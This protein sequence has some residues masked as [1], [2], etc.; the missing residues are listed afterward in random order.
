VPRIGI[1]G[2]GRI[3]ASHLAALETLESAEV[4]A[5]VDIEP[6]RALTFR[7]QDRPVYGRHDDLLALAVDA[8]VVATPTPTHAEI[9]ARLLDHDSPAAI[10]VEKPLA[11]SYGEWR[12]L[13]DR[14]RGRRATVTTLLHA[15]FAPEVLWAADKVPDLCQRHGPVR[16]VDSLFC[17]PYSVDDEHA[18]SSYVSS[19]I[20]SGIN[21]LSVLARLVD[22]ER[23]VTLH[24]EDDTRDVWKAR[25]TISWRGEPGE[26]VVHTSWDEPEAPKCTRL[27]FADSTVLALDHKAMTATLEADGGGR[28][29]YRSGTDVPRL[30]Q[31]YRNMWHAWLRDRRF[32]GLPDPQLHHILLA[33]PAEPPEES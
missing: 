10:L 33:G 3:A 7:G 1:V 26:A 18:R 13:M 15:A 25:V 28:G 12:M 32:A 20:D 2:L 31:H 17:D 21:A 22:L 4:V 29:A 14:P 8:V 27:T 23:L 5:G 6:G 11:A 30:T 19:W 9:A 16:Q 24:N